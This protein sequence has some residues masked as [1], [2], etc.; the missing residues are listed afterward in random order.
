MAT[1]D[2]FKIEEPFD[3]ENVDDFM[4]DLQAEYDRIDGRVQR[5]LLILWS[6]IFLIESADVAVLGAF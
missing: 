6:L 2:E 5:K 4:S 1:T 3:T